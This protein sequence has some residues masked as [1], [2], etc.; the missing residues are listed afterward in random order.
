M[1]LDRSS[2]QFSE[3]LG[4]FVRRLTI[5]SSYSSINRSSLANFLPENTGG[6]DDSQAQ[7]QDEGDPEV[8]TGVSLISLEFPRQLILISLALDLLSTEESSV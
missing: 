1:E 2:L 6:L 7:H 5:S 4:Y 3:S 8:V